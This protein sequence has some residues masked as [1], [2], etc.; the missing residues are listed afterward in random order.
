MT[1]TNLLPPAL[2]TE[3]F[4]SGARRDARVA[5]AKDENG[6]RPRY[7]LISP[8]GVR[9]I[10]ETYGE[11]ALKYGDHNWRAGMPFST[12][13]NH[14][15]AHLFQWLRGE[16]SEDHLA[17]AAWGLLALMHFEE[18]HPELNDIKTD[19]YRSQSEPEGE[20]VTLEQLARG[21]CVTFRCYDTDYEAIVSNVD[22]KHG[23]FDS[24]NWRLIGAPFYRKGGRFY[25]PT[26][27]RRFSGK[28]ARGTLSR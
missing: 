1:E 6:P 22:L 26:H 23:A 5:G 7:D 18:T 10:A 20:S 17:H 8:I 27:I 13:V 3:Q 14:V 12:T 15:L 2:T 19:D 9:R 28:T 21:D 4:E 25:G 24:D 16:K 11:G